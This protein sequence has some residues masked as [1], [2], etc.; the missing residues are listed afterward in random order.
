VKD[1]VVPPL[2]LVGVLGMSESPV[3]YLDP[4]PGESLTSC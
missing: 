4:P 3:R 2:V 1:V